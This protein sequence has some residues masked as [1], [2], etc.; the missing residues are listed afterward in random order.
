MDASGVKFYEV[1]KECLEFP[2]VQ[3]DSRYIQGTEPVVNAVRTNSKM[4]F[5]STC[6]KPPGPCFRC[7]ELHWIRECPFREH[8]CKRCNKKA[9]LEKVCKSKDSSIKTKHNYQKKVN[10]IGVLRNSIDIDG[11]LHI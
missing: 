2:A 10:S 11:L 8:Y 4:K 1:A 3:A 5:K 6:E 9:H 7:N